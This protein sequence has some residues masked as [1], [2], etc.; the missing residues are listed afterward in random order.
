MDSFGKRQANGHGET[1]QDGKTK[2]AERTHTQA[3]A[4]DFAAFVDAAF[5]GAIIAIQSQSL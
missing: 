1:P 2:D 5:N 3:Y 4:S